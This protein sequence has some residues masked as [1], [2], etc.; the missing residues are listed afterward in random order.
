[1]GKGKKGTGR[2]VAWRDIGIEGSYTIELSFCGV[3]DNAETK[4]FRKADEKRFDDIL[5]ARNGKRKKRSTGGGG[6]GGMPAF[7]A[8][9]AFTAGGNG[10]TTFGSSFGEP[11]PIKPGVPSMIPL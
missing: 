2:V 6:G 3:G 9:G 8:G 10:G 11:P 7:S 1:M 4:L 5:D